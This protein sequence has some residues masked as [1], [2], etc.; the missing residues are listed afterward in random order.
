MSKNEILLK[1]HEEMAK[2]GRRQL[3][4]ATKPSGCMRGLQLAIEIIKEHKE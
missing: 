4:N 1:L 3:P 2:A